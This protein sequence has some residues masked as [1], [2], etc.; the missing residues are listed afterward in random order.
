MIQCFLLARIFRVLGSSVDVSFAMLF[1]VSGKV[2]LER[3]FG[4]AA[5]LKWGTERRNS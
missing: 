4:N 5:I 1:Q 2:W 3:E